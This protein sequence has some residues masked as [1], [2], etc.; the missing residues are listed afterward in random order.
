M[1]FN[2]TLTDV[3]KLAPLPKLPLAKANIAADVTFL[4]WVI[5]DKIVFVYWEIPFNF[6][7]GAY[8]CLNIVGNISSSV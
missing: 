4:T 3:P 2:T 8:I 5:G 6:I 7:I 1:S